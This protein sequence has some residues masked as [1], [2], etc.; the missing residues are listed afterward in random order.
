MC[1]EGAEKSNYVSTA[2]NL[3]PFKRVVVQATW[4]KY[5]DNSI[6][7]TIN[8]PVAATVE[9]IRELYLLAYESGC[10]GL[11]IFRDGCKRVG[12]LTNDIKN[13]NNIGRGYIKSIS[14]ELKGRKRKLITGCGS[15]HCSA[16]FN[17]NGD[18]REVFLAKGSQ[19]GCANFMHSLSRMIS[20]SARAGVSLDDIVDQLESSGTCPSYAVRRATKKDTSS[21]NSCP[22]AIGRILIEMQKEFKDEL[23]NDNCQE[24][25]INNCPTCGSQ[26]VM[27]EGCTTCRSCGWSKCS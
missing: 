5:I 16:F 26:M 15:L 6:S 25:V 4:Q 7:S 12:V 27:A 19:G 13:G 14:N 20:L 21:G 8:L 9:Q 24:I 23:S 18:L 11:T 1:G 17:D 22:T 10:K 3:D 2:H